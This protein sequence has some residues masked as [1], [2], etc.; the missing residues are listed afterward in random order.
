MYEITRMHVYICM[1][2]RGYMY[3]VTCA[4]YDACTHTHT[5]TH[6]HHVSYDPCTYPRTHTHHVTYTHTHTSCHIYTHTHT[7]MMSR[8]LHVHT[9]THT[10]TYHVPVIHTI[11]GAFGGKVIMRKTA[12][13]IHMRA[14]LHMCT[15]MHISRTDTC[16]RFFADV[17][18]R[19]FAFV[20]THMIYIHICIY[21]CIYT[22]IYIHTYVYTYMYMHAY[23]YRC[24]NVYTYMYR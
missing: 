22:C 15:C 6:T 11:H 3:I 24:T 12:H 17:C 14:L 18:V 7:H 16:E 5:H 13:H 8:M 1:R 10:H 20:Y 23:I 21:I 9:N 2:S 4:P 19:V